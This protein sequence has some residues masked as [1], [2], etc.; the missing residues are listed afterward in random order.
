MKNRSIQVATATALVGVLVAGVVLA[1]SA[2]PAR[3]TPTAKEKAAVSVYAKAVAKARLA[4]LAEISPSR[5]AV[6]AVGKT[7]E[8]V[9]RAKVKAALNTFNLV[10]ASAKAPTLAAEKSYKAEAAKLT[11]NP[12]N[13]TLKAG[14]KASLLKLNERCAQSKCQSY[15]RPSGIHQGSRCGDGCLQSGS[16]ALRKTPRTSSTACDG[17]VQG[18]TSKGPGE[19]EGRHQ[20]GAS[21]A[22]ANCGKSGT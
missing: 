14:V 4:F 6:I 15:R 8:A 17:E 16:R 12:A 18:R 19:P 11:A 22:V 13:T 21:K 3:S 20:V 10:V 1:G 5:K 9:R 2:T 7:A